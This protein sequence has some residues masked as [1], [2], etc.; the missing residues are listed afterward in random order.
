MHVSCGDFTVSL[1]NSKGDV[2][3]LSHAHSDHLFGTTRVRHFLSSDAT[4]DLAGISRDVS[5]FSNLRMIDAGHILGARQLVIESDGKKTIYSGDFSTS[6]NIFDLKAQIEECDHLIMEATYG[7]PVYSLPDQSQVADDLM[8][9]LKSASS[10]SICVL[11]GYDLGKA[12]ELIK[13]ANLCGIVPLVN[14]KAESFC[15][16]YAKHGIKLDRILIGT[17]EAEEAMSRD[18]VAVVP[19]RLAN[20]RFC[21]N[22]SRAF[23]RSVKCAV[24]TGWA[25]GSSFSSDASFPLSDHAD[26]DDLVEYVC[27][28]GAKSVEFFCGDGSKVLEKAKM[29]MILNK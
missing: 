10:S 3:F 24:A 9:W 21:S 4:R 19:M 17:T 2:A 23:G 27:A 16:V 29:S 13:L 14:E 12:Q 5:S 25:T 8:R 11:G 26:F 22:L 15:Q 18:F 20:R 1:D 6:P 28:T 7:D